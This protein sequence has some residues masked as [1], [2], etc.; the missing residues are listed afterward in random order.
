MR[1]SVIR[2]RKVCSGRPC[3]A[4]IKNVHRVASPGNVRPLSVLQAKPEGARVVP[5]AGC[6]PGDRAF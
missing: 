5:G 2:P 4:S 1:E 6:G 3:P